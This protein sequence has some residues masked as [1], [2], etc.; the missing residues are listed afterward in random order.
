MYMQ[1]FEE[2]DYVKK[3][4]GDY[5]FAGVVVSAFRKYD[6]E[7]KKQTG[8]WRYAVQNTDGLVHIFNGRQLSN[9]IMK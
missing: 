4:T 7:L 2:G 6:K 8:P 3:T 9:A 5:T 1:M